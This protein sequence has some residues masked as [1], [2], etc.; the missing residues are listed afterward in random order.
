MGVAW[1]RNEAIFFM[2]HSLKIICKKLK[3]LRKEKKVV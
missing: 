3:K 1:Y 2:G